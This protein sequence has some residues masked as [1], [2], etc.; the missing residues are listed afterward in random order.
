MSILG[1]VIFVGLF[2][3][4]FILASLFIMARNQSYDINM[5]NKKLKN[6]LK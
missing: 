1:L 2:I 5:E 3:A 6:E 4:V